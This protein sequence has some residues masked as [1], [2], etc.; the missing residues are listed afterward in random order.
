VIIIETSIFTR[1][2]RTLLSGEE[3]RKLQTALLLHPDRGAIIPGSG[4][5]R[6]VRWAMQ[7]RGK[8]GG[9]RTI[10]YWAVSNDQ[11]LMLLMYAKNEQ[12]NL[13]P[14]QLKVLRHIVEEEYP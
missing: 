6:K 10:Y 2:V 14:E 13:T 11:I 4:G 8:R 7:G 3:Y 1:Q 12:D 9:V 5:L